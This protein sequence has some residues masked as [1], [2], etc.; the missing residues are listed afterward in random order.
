[1]RMVPSLLFN[2]DC[3]LK[4]TISILPDPVFPSGLTSKVEEAKKYQTNFDEAM[5]DDF[6]TADAIA[7]VFDLVKESRIKILETIKDGVTVFT[8]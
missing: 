7:A 2:V 6:N 8:A 3:G 1:M 4:R 5:D